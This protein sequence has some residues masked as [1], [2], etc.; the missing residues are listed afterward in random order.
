MLRNNQYIPPIPFSLK[1][2]ALLRIH[3]GGII[4]LWVLALIYYLI[5]PPIVPIH[6][7]F[8]GQPTR[9]GNKDLLF[10]IPALFSLIPFL[11]IILSLIRFKLF[12]KYP[13]LLNLPSVFFQKNHLSP[14]Q[15]GILL[16]KYFEV[17][18][19][20]S[21]IL[22]LSLLLIEAGIFMGMHSGTLPLWTL[23]IVLTLPF[24][25]IILLV[26]KIK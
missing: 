22:T 23:V 2:K 15:T 26:V 9:Y 17:I 25:T 24:Y 20:M 12:N 1:G 4:A 8:T 21:S 11:F 3:I 18:L 13:A 10:I 14:E 19:T 5:L 6:F 7:D 16:N